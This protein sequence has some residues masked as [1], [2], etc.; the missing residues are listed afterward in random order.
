MDASSYPGEN[1]RA[2]DLLRLASEYRAAA[3]HLLKLGRKGEPTSRAPCR[4]VAIH[5]IELYLNAHLAASGMSLKRIRG[6]H[7]DLAQRAHLAA[8]F[9]LV[10]RKRTADHLARLTGDREYLE[11]RYDPDMTTTQVN[12]LIAT[13]DELAKKVANT[14]LAV[15]PE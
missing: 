5:A 3:H 7:H 10:L 4:L 15:P 2:S 6:L 9:G 8:S 13:M 1:A 11:T 14:A 12:D